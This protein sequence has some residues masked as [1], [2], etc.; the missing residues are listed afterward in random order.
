MA[1]CVNGSHLLRPRPVSR[2]RLLRMNR[3]LSLDPGTN[4]E[5]LGLLGRLKQR[6][7]TS[8]LLISHDF[9]V[10]TGISNRITIMYAGRIVEQGSIDEALRGGAPSLYV[11]P[12]QVR[13]AAAEAKQPG[14]RQV[15]CA[16]YRWADCRPER[17]YALL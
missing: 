16:N 7:H 2:P 5:I 13:L 15:S 10:L 11:R 17:G 14:I 1:A 9:S 8:F 3:Q 4:S 6:L 12:V